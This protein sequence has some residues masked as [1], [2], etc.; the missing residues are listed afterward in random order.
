MHGRVPTQQK[1]NRSRPPNRHT[2]SRP[3]ASRG[4]RTTLNRQ[5]IG[6]A[7]PMLRLWHLGQRIAALRCCT[8]L[9]GLPL[10]TAAM[11]GLRVRVCVCTLGRKAWKHTKPHCA[12]LCILHLQ[13]SMNKSANYPCY[14]APGQHQSGSP[15]S[16][17]SARILACLCVC[18]KDENGNRTATSRSIGSGLR[19]RV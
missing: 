15:R 7:L 5:P 13:E 17:A 19:A 12:I 11:T 9:S 8:I 10:T 14:P 2:A 1:V 16:W 4:R 18:Q 6:N 3:D